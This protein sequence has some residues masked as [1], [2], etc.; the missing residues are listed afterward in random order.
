ML[1]S[2][3]PKLVLYAAISIW[4][5]RKTY[6]ALPAWI[7]PGGQAK[8]DAEKDANDDIANP[9]VIIKKLHS[10]MK[11]CQDRVDDDLPWFKI[12]ACFLSYIHLRRELHV[13][14]PEH[15]S[16]RYQAQGDTV[17]TPELQELNQYC[18]LAKWAYLGS[19]IDLH[20]NLKS[21]GYDLLRHDTATEPGRVGHFI[22]VNHAQ[23][24]AIISIKGTN[25][26]SDALTDVLGHAVNH[27]LKIPLQQPGAGGA[28]KAPI[29]SI[30]VHEGMYTA[31]NM[32]YSDTEH[33]LDNFFLPCDY[34]VLV[35]GHSLGAGVACL[36]GLFLQCR[37]DQ[38][39]HDN[40]RVLA[41]ATPAC[42]DLATATA[43]APFTTSVVNNTD[44]VPRMSVMNLVTL[45]KLFVK[46]DEKLKEHGRSPS[47]WKSSKA[48]V[49]DL[50]KIDDNLLMSPEE[51]HAFEIQI[52]KDLKQEENEDSLFVPGRVVVLWENAAATSDFIEEA[53]DCRVG[54]GGMTV[55]RH[56][57]VETTMLT[58]HSCAKYLKNL[59]ALVENREKSI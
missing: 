1:L 21:R 32:I 57:E 34:K 25:T 45:N 5:T 18:Q 20:A 8:K 43:V 35:T 40:V 16:Q 27:E 10:M 31:A 39:T 51:L 58:D 33:L 29:E 15:K 37:M 54:D 59:A 28:K 52:V 12:Y 48:L 3:A 41:F 2:E 42:L 22:A 17:S 6:K 30:R 9:S 4:L 23:K 55:L 47:S 46:V 19:Y 7:K 26:L 56:L 50:M 11:L 14:H 13:A 44:C 53:V 36:L 24:L 49:G 38:T